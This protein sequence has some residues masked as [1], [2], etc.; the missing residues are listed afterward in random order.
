[1]GVRDTD[2]LAEEIEGQIEIT[3]HKADIILFVVDIRDGIT[4]LFNFYNK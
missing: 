4:P 1:M 2:G 3:L